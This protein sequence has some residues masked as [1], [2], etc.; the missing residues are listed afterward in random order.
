M[1][2]EFDQNK[3]GPRDCPLPQSQVSIGGIESPSIV[4]SAKQRM[5]GQMKGLAPGSGIRSSVTCMH[6]FANGTRRNR[7]Q[8]RAQKSVACGL[9]ASASFY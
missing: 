1:P 5:K 8:V 2:E 3:S 7:H 9:R 6:P 4:M